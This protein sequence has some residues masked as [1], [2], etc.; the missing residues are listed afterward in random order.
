MTGEACGTSQRLLPLQRARGACEIELV[1]QLTAGCAINRCVPLWH[2]SI[3]RAPGYCVK[4]HCVTHPGVYRCLQLPINY[5]CELLIWGLA[6]TEEVCMAL[7]PG[8]CIQ[9]CMRDGVHPRAGTAFKAHDYK[10]VGNCGDSHALMLP[11]FDARYYPL[12][13][14]KVYP[15]ARLPACTRSRGGLQS[16]APVP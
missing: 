12:L 1:L 6:L 5:A 2:P 11:A 9:N 7:R 3:L 8:P 14:R 10:C 15:A 16:S 4:P 13:V